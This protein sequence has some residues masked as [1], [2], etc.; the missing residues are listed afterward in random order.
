MVYQYNFPEKISKKIDAFIDKE[1][2]EFQ[3]FRHS[4]THVSKDIFDILEDKCIVVYYPIFDEENDGFHVTRFIKGVPK[5]FVY[6]NTAKA[7]EKQIFTAAHELGHMLRLE[8]YLQLEC[9]DSYTK[10]LQEYCVNR[11]AA[12]LLLPC[13]EVSEVIISKMMDFSENDLDECINH[14]T[15]LMNEFFVPFKT[16]VYRLYELEY[17]SKN[18]SEK[19]LAYEEQENR[20]FFYIERNNY[21]KLNAPDSKKEI[22]GYKEILSKAEEGAVF[23]KDKIDNIRKLF[24]INAS[25]KNE[26]ALNNGK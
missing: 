1:S 7:L 12:K 14:I 9:P 5:D 21:F 4:G 24:E 16:V 13:T 25:K 22:S 26:E 23:S 15:F 2:S 19:I 11:F 6:I 8:D 20:V 17:I 18:Q 10:D 3:K